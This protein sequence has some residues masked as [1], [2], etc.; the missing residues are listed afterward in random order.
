M[1]LQNHPNAARYLLEDMVEDVI[2]RLAF[3]KAELKTAL[4]IGDWTGMLA[5][6]L[7][8]QGVEV[9]QADPAGLALSR[10]TKSSPICCA[11]SILSPRSARSI[12]SD[13]PGALIHMRQALNPGVMIASFVGAGSLPALRAIMLAADGDRPA[14]RVHPMVDVRAG[15]NCCNAPV[16]PIRSATGA[17]SR[18][19]SARWPALSPM[20]GLRPLAAC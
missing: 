1:V 12:R 15:R 5:A 18:S 4:V 19:I 2:E 3:V 9:T 7:R 20:C 14:A 17:A 11:V 6:N 8:A 10:L 13:L 16:M